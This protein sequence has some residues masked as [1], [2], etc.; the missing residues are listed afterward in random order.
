M[1]ARHG[2]LAVLELLQLPRRRGR[3]GVKCRH[4]LLRRGRKGKL[5]LVGVRF[6]VPAR[7]LVPVR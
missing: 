3:F 1:A 7:E 6:D 5:C 4:L 2:H